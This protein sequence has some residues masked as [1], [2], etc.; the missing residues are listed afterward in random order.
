MQKEV[1]TQFFSLK[2]NFLF[3]PLSDWLATRIKIAMGLIIIQ[4]FLSFDECVSHEA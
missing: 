2:V 1:S 3:I 4:I